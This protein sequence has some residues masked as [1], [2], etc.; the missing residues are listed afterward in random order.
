MYSLI[1][2]FI[3]VISI[4]N[5]SENTRYIIRKYIISVLPIY[6]ENEKWGKMVLV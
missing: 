6:L 4:T 2:I 5:S 3:V 1:K